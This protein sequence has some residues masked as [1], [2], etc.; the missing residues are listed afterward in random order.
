MNKLISRPAL[1][2]STASIVCMLLGGAAQA[3]SVPPAAETTADPGRIS[4]QLREYEL[5]P[6]IMP[7]IEVSELRL[8]EPPPGAE[9]MMFQLDRLVLEGVS[10]YNDADLRSVYGDRLGHSISLAELYLVADDITRKYRND[11]Y[12]L[13]QTAIPP[14]TIEGGTAR[15]QIVE[16]FIS[17]VR[18]QG[19]GGPA[20]DLIRIYA[21]R[22]ETGG[23]ALNARDLE[24]TL[25]LIN[26]LPGVS[27]R[28]VLGRS[29]TEVGGAD[30]TIIV[31]RDPLDA[32]LAVD[33]YGSR[34]LGPVQGTA[35]VT[36]NNYFFNQN[37]QITL[38]TALAPDNG[39]ELAYYSASYEQ[40]I[41]KYGTTIEAFASYT[42]TDPGYTLARFGVEGR[43]VFASLKVEHPVIRSR[44][45][46]LLTRA[47]F[48]WRDVDS[49]NL[50][51][52]TR[53]DRIRAM[54]LGG[55]FQWLDTTFLGV[56]VNL[57]DL[58]FSQGIDIMG[59]SDNGSSTLSRP[60]AD[61][62]FTKL[63]AQIQRLQ[64]VTGDINLLLA[65]AGQ[66]SNEALL[67]SEEFGVGG[68]NFGRGF[69][70]SEIVG[71]DGVSGKVELQ[72]NEPYPWEFV[73]DY[74][75][76]GFYDAGRVWNDD[77]TTSDGERETATS[78]GFGVRS[79]FMEE[80]EA[81]LTVAFPLNR[82][83]ATQEDRDPR[84]Y[85][86]LSRRF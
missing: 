77:S 13:T 65:A 22:I 27:A 70:P 19:E 1:F 49:K 76:F 2:A 35:A 52:P 46:D 6:D 32:L 5:S 79:E 3:T 23:R 12:L 16:G 28:A 78:A 20:N 8:R 60:A 75:V 9:N 71:D 56:G 61:G 86:S 67:S 14:Q 82:D 72:W 18:V 80:T 62:V 7:E 40:P 66:I 81:D 47:Q 63:E 37:E 58:E 42:D 4:Q 29:E 73:Q 54:R 30:L 74:Q 11:G 10:V 39:L 43:S 57:I 33:N 53:E 83:V 50:I 21:N 45:M 84:V 24:H 17:S 41:W 85:F 48:D 51:E 26:D 59:A 36:L 15:I 68:L 44:K 34:F 55:T 64:R 25:F 38:Q 69:D 31:E